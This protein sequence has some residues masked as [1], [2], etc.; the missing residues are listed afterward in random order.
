MGVVRE[1]GAINAK[2]VIVFR[3]YVA[4]ERVIARRRQFDAV[5]VVRC[6]VVHERVIARRR[7][8]DAVLFDAVLFDAVLFMSVLLLLEEYRWMP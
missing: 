8:F 4:Y 6:S 2:V 1:S 7:Q 5:P 3:H